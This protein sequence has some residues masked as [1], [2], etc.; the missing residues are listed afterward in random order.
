MK[1]LW[2]FCWLSF[3]TVQAGMGAQDPAAE[4][5]QAAV[6][7]NSQPDTAR[8]N[9]LNKLAF[10]LRANASKRSLAAYQQALSLARKLGYMEGEATALLGL[11]FYY[12]FRN[13]YGLGL[14]YTK[15]AQ[16]L[17][18]ELG[19]ELSQIACLYN[20]SYAVSGQGQFSQAMA[21]SLEGLHIATA[22][23]SQK[24]ITLLNSQLGN[25]CLTVGEYGKAEQYLLHGLRLAQQAGD[26]DGIVHCLSGLGELYGRQR[27]WPEALRYQEQQLALAEQAG[28]QGWI[29]IAQ[30]A[31]AEVNE[32]IGDYPKAFAGL[33]Q[34]LKRLRKLDAVGSL[35]RAHLILARA[36]LHTDRPDSALIYGQKSL[37]ASQSN[38][39]KSVS[40][41]AS[42][43]L[44]EAN[45][46][47]GRFPEAYR[48]HVL[49]MSYKDSLNSQ[50][51]LR[52]TAALQYTYELDKQ[53]SQ[54]RL[55]T[56]NEQLS[57]QR[58]NQQRLLLFG[59]LAALT[60][61]A[62]L[63]VLL[64]RNNQQKQRANALLSQQKEEM[65]AQRDQ[66]HQALTELRATQAQLVQ[67]EKMASLGELTAGIAH[68]MQNPLNFVT[69]FSEVSAEL[70]AELR[71]AHANEA[72]PAQETDL[73]AS[74][75]QNLYKIK[76]H[77]Q[78]ASRIV[79]G[80]LEH[81]RR[82]GGVRQPTN[83]NTV[84]IEYLRLAYHGWRA[85][86]PACS[87]EVRTEWAPTLPPVPIVVAELG[88]V[89]LNIL[90]NAFYAV[91]QR[92]LQEGA[93]YEP[94]VRISTHWVGDQVL[95]K[96]RD[97]G[98]GIP[99]SIQ[100]KIFQPFFTTK[101]PG[102][103]TGLGLSLSYDIVT[104]G[105][106][107]SLT[108]ESQEGEYTEFTIALPLTV[109]DNAPLRYQAQPETTEGN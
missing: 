58:A 37:Q 76:Q 68:E 17:F 3:L 7:A 29:T 86:G 65:Q 104:Q 31:I 30:L 81:A 20:L 18:Q 44:A 48:Y 19:D 6:Q 77:G 80:M 105:Y 21:Y 36:Y 72:A 69:N 64:W 52:R 53:Q 38:G 74:L 78:Q 75:T 93:G 79:R 22:L 51:L 1:T 57:R 89:L 106:G 16:K 61:V 101:P 92:K 73:W 33:F 42:S 88:R 4:R 70:V 28:N 11:G 45:A 56:R 35:P 63:S 41:D 10:A 5:L 55:L 15:Q 43:V 85:H 83:L 34:C 108:V 95:I 91:E 67:Q 102:E 87:V 9:L 27:K 40:R 109:L 98:V 2:L 24:W 50:D 54:I 96:V 103:G 13:E 39:T 97:N 47:L 82:P 60:I 100:R 107:G 71:A 12:R 59:S 26:Q 23:H 66:I 8:V 94:W 25:T 46:R 90:A 99:E 49:F 62:G 14:T 32:R 84:C